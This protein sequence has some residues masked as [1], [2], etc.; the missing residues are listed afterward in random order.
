MASDT[1]IAIKKPALRRRGRQKKPIDPKLQAHICRS[2]FRDAKTYAT[3]RWELEQR[4][5]MTG[6]NSWY[7][8]L[9]TNA[10]NQGLIFFD[11]DETFTFEGDELEARHFRD[12]S[13]S[14]MP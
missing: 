11:V 3:I 10:R 1:P 6:D 14:A 5:I 9:V 8:N 13:I 12:S 4:G 2:H 7:A